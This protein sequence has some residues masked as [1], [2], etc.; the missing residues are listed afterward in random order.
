LTLS[1]PTLH[2]EVLEGTFLSEF[3]TMMYYSYNQY[4]IFLYLSLMRPQ[5]LSRTRPPNSQGRPCLL[6]LLIAT[7]PINTERAHT[8]YLDDL[9]NAQ[10]V[11]F[12]VF[13]IYTNRNAIRTTVRVNL[14][15][16]QTCPHMRSVRVSG[17]PHVIDVALYCSAQW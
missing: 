8:M 4:I 5:F 6:G 15:P 13:S 11:A 10:P 17:E 14:R 1:S 12:F 16:T 3:H 2:L 9:N 7:T